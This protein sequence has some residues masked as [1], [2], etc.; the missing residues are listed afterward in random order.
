MNQRPVV[1]LTRRLPER[2]EEELGRRYVVRLP[3]DDTAPSVHALELMLR[4][5]DALVCTVTDALPAA[6]FESGPLRCR[7]L[8]NFG[9]GVNHIDLEAARHVGITVTN[10]PDQLTETTADLTL[11]LMLMTLRRLGEGAR[12]LRAGEWGGWRPTDFLGHD[13]HG[14][15]LGVVGFG[16]IGQAVARRAALGFGMR[17]TAVGR[18]GPPSATLPPFVTAARSLDALLGM[19]DV[20]S[21]HLPATALNRH[22]FNAAR[23]GRMRP[24]SWF[25]NTAR[26]SLV[27]EAALIEAV[28]SG[29]LAGAGLDVFEGEP[30]INPALLDCPGLVLLPHMGSA[31]VA[32]REG[33]GM[34]VVANLEAFFADQPLL[35]PVA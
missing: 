20:V 30:R 2:V 25:I 29:L 31:T 7:M 34:R 6:L 33:M 3:D 17:V 27:D 28:R 18:D 35:D 1:R 13:L 26:G 11:G 9:A 10:T 12:I 16:R 32:A 23:F 14:R 21:L 4:E 22:L 8:A 5:C 24:G 19:V 15:T